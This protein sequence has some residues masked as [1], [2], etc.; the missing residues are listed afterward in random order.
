MKP[1]FSEFSYGFALTHEFC[2]AR[3]GSLAAAPVFPSLVEEGKSTV[4]FDVHLKQPGAPLFLQFKISQY[5]VRRT[6]LHWHLFNKPHYR[7]WLHAARRSTQHEALLGQDKAPNVVLYAAPTIHKA[8][9]LDQAFKNRAVVASS[10]FFRPQDIGRLP[11]NAEHC[12]AFL[13][14]T[15]MGYFCSQ[16]KQVEAAAHGRSIFEVLGSVFR[17]SRRAEPTAEY[18]D[19]L[20]D[21]LEG[22]S[23]HTA[24]R[25][26][27]ERSQANPLHRARERAAY[28]AR[29]MLGAELLWVAPAPRLPN[30]ER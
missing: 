21:K 28:A 1:A 23:D 12:I 4:G 29:T 27:P 22:G 19:A 3:F 17:D 5:M 16:P 8:T 24:R 10:V 9:D 18:F 6:A 11:D 13:P 14:G 26:I 7:F 25:V 20:A 15:G 30:E 2:V